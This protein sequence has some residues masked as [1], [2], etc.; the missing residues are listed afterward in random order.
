[1]IA[2]AA[3]SSAGLTW[4]ILK[5]KILIWV[6]FGGSWN[7]KGC[8]YGI[9]LECITAIWYTLWVFGNLVALRYIFPRFGILCH[10]KSGNPD[11]VF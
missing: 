3:W 7:E 9:H 4:F 1:M 10:E 8:T 5:P 2:L 11:L 6:N